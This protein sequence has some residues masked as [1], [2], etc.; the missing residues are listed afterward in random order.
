MAHLMQA[1][2]ARFSILVQPGTETGDRKAIFCICI[3]SIF[4][5]DS[6]PLVG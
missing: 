1:S 5:I 2:I 3:F 4:S 6:A